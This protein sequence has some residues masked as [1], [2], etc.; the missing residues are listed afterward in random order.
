MPRHTLMLRD[1]PTPAAGDRLTITGDEA[2]HAIRVKRVRAGDSLT[3]LDGEGLLAH[4]H[5][6]DARRD[7][8]VVIDRVERVEPTSPRIEVF[9]AAPKGQRFE[10][11]VDS[12][13]QVGA[14]GVVP[15]E[16]DFGVVE[17]GANKM[18]RAHRVAEEAS[19][20]SGRAWLLCVGEQI[21]FDEA[22]AGEGVRVLCDADAPPYRP[23]GAEEI[24]LLVGPEGGWSPAERE[25]AEA[26]GA[27]RASFGVHT[28]RIEVAAPS[29]CAIALHLEHAQR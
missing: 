12:C 14:H 9:A 3:I 16:T 21:A 18:Q 23:S 15:I 10:Q 25:R 22:L 20:Q 29:A 24:R 26:A 19:K 28:M 8:V 13:A 17:P 4:A 7:L 1:A 2:K 6:E 5:A 11:M 27:M